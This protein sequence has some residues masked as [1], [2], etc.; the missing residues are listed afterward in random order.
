MSLRFDLSGVA[1][2]DQSF[3]FS[4]TYAGVPLNLSGYTLALYLKDSAVTPDALATVYAE[5]TGLT[6]TSAPDGQFTWDAPAA[7]TVISAPGALWYRVDVI[8]SGSNATPAM[9]GALNLAAA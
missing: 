7:D 8:D 9:F 3:D 6:L 4:L 5:G 2:F 1:G